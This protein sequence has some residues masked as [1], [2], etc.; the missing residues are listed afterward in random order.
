M[1]NST[2]LTD[3][4]DT[5]AAEAIVAAGGAA[6]PELLE[7]VQD[8]NWPVAKILAPF[9][10]SAG[11]NVVPEIRQIFASNDDTWKWSV[12][13]GVVAKSSELI[14]LLRPELERIVH[15]PTV[16]ERSEGLEQFVAKLLESA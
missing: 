1:P 6:A 2:K 12:V 11:S 3:K 9:L 16:G 15:A 13:V 5:R 8:I 7:W 14:A 10:A 4:S